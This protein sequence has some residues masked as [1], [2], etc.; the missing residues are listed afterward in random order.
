MARL[1]NNTMKIKDAVLAKSNDYLLH[2]RS[3]NQ[4][5][6]DVLH[7]ILEDIPRWVNESITVVM[8]AYNVASSLPKTLSSLE[9]QTYRNF[10]VIVVNDGSK[11]DLDK[12][13]ERAHCSYPLHYIKNKSNR[14]R[15]Y[16][17]NTGI[18]VASGDTILILDP[19]MVISPNHLLNV[20]ARQQLLKDCVL[21][22]FKHHVDAVDP[23]IELEN[24][25]K[26][27]QPDYS[28]DWRVHR[29]YD[30][31]MTPPNCMGAKEHISR[32]ISILN[33]TNY[34][35]SLGQ[36]RIIGAWDASSLVIGHTIAVKRK[37]AIRAGGFAEEFVGW[38]PDDVAFGYRVVATGCYVV[39]CTSAAGYHINHEPHSGSR[40]K[41]MQEF[42]VNVKRIR[43]LADNDMSSLS[44]PHK[45]V[46]CVRREGNKHYCEEV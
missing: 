21:V 1:E 13:I 6:F 4:A 40:E 5:D 30:S 26:G 28:T 19:D 10:E 39:P 43:E 8:P 41:K 38:G 33:E 37:D 36:G 16:A 23:C 15:P 2:M 31:T 17:R 29:V 22:G 25:A 35:S 14:D 9:M 7:T 24:I 3:V 12:V 34:F 11:E 42:H 20:A 18:S 46:R 27:V 32:K 45:K 44:F